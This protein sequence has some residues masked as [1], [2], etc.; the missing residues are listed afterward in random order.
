MVKKMIIFTCVLGPQD[1]KHPD[2]LSVT[3][4]QKSLIVLTVFFLIPKY[5]DRY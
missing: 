1:P 4:K 5:V 2:W 3:F